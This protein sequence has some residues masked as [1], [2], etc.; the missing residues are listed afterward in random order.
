MSSSA[1]TLLTADE[2][3]KMP[4]VDSVRFELDEGDLIEMPPGGLRHSLIGV[5][6]ISRLSVFA[7]RSKLGLVYGPDSGFRLS[8]C[9]VR[10]PDVS[11]VRRDRVVDTDEYFPGAP[12]LAVEVFSPSDRIRQLRRKGKQYFDA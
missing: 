8:D 9:T 7:E 6:I 3:W 4:D 2:L 5:R 1:K 11:F 12:D 10:A